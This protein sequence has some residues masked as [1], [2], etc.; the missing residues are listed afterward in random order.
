MNRDI[1]CAITT[2]EGCTRSDVSTYLCEGME[3]NKDIR[4]I[5]M[6]DFQIRRLT[7]KECFRLMGFCPMKEDGTFDDSNYYKAAEVVS[8]SQ[9][10][11][12]MG[13]SIVVDCLAAIFKEL[14]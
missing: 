8:P 6:E 14:M 11:K 2:R 13:N 5:N 4:N 3:P 9:L 12:Q 1:A 7:E 10:L